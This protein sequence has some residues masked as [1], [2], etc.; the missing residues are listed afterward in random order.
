MADHIYLSPHLDDAV[1]SC[2]GVIYQQATAGEDVLI[3][4]V[5]A[6]DPEPDSLSPFAQSLHERWG[7]DGVSIE[8]RRKEDLHA[9]ERLG[10][11]T[12]HLLIPEAIYRQDVEGTFLY[13]SEEAIFGDLHPSEDD[14]P[15]H[16]AD[17]LTRV[18]FEPSSVDVQ[19]YVPSGYGGHVDH[20]LLRESVR[21]LEVQ[22]IYY[23]D[24][25]YAMRGDQIPTEYPVEAREEL[26]V[27][28]SDHEIQTWAKAVMDYK[29]QLSTFW[30]DGQ[31]IE[32]ELRE[33]HDQMGGIPLLARA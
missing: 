8:E 23:R 2:G 15:D 31:T 26:R 24:F 16:L 17:L 29:S 10:V 21:M 33:A 1:F 30:E 22:E 6:G 18:L 28:L 32:G 25:P 13:D 20:K 12:L 7:L 11:Q 5:C 3:A 9:C 19:I 27:H 4:T 14:L